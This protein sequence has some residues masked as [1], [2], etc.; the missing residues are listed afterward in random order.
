LHKKGH[1][2]LKNILF[3]KKTIFSISSSLSVAVAV[4]DAVVDV[5]VV[6]HANVANAKRA[7]LQ[8]LK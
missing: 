2:S 5:V 3:E 4:V 8:V 1:L 6:D 7:E